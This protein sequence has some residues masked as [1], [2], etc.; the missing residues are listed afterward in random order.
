MLI[1]CFAF[2]VLVNVV[3]WG[4]R[5]GGIGNGVNAGELEII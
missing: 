3:E 4:G 5:K 1:S 2:Q